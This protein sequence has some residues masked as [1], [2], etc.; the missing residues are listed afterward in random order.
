MKING[1]VRIWIVLSV[2]WCGSVLFLGYGH[3]SEI[4]QQQRF[5]V[6]KAGVGSATFV[7]SRAQSPN[8]VQAFINE[9]LVPLVEKSPADYVGLVTTAPYNAYVRDHYASELMSLAQLALMPV[10][11]LLVFG[12]SVTWIKRGFAEKTGA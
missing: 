2:A 6:T 11:G 5:E 7:F 4:T 9:D 3:I 10:F 1:W 8:V 12:W